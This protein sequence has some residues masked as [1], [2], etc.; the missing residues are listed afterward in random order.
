MPSTEIALNTNAF[1]GSFVFF[2]LIK[3]TLKNPKEPPNQRKTT[4]QT[5]SETS[6]TDI[7]AAYNSSHTKVGFMWLNEEL[8]IYPSIFLVSSESLRN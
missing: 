1:G 4:R 7:S 3:P 6:S 2:S 5:M 8:L